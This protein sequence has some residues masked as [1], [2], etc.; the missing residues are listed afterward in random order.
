M[1]H[2]GLSGCR[3]R[4]RNPHRARRPSLISRPPDREPRHNLRGQY[5]GPVLAAVARA[6]YTALIRTKYPRLDVE[7]VPAPGRPA[8]ELVNRS[9]DCTLIVL[10]H[11]ARGGFPRLAMGSVTLQVATHARC[12]VIVVRALPTA[13]GQA[14]PRRPRRP[15]TRARRG[16][17]VERAIPVTRSPRDG[18]RVRGRVSAESRAKTPVRE[19]DGCGH[20]VD[21]VR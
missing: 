18:G 4:C 9:G 5:S 16:R 2:E 1:W 21:Q 12:P 13:H 14:Q 19:L 3:C 15:Q 10:G 7:E 8:T 6:P 20:L 11:R 17:G